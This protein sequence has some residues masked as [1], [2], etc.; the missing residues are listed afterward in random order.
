MNP[1]KMSENLQK[2]NAYIPGIRPGAETASYISR[3]LFKITM[4]GATY[5]AVVA[6]IPII[7][8]YI[9]DL[10]NSVQLG[11]TSLII[12]VGVAI[13]TAKQL[14]TQSQDKQYRGFID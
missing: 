6:A 1:E 9:F 2:Q 11:G 5:L 3:V 4:V 14:K 13:E 8:S 12:V 10:P 7:T